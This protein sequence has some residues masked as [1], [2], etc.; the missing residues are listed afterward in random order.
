[1]IYHQA[2]AELNPLT[3]TVIVTSRFLQDNI[4]FILLIGATL[5]LI[6]SLLYRK[7]KAFRAFIQ[8]ISM[9]M[10]VLGKIIIYK[11]MNIF[12]KT[13]SSL[14]KNNVFITD[15]IDILTSITKN[16]I[17]RDIMIETID[18]IAKGEKN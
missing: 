12:A 16:E 11:E 18:N 7:V 6:I 15:S 17:Y 5:V 1:M 3:A 14:L 9:K 2:G 4:S 8:K 10:P 13:F